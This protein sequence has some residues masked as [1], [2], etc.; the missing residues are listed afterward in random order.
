MTWLSAG[1]I[2]QLMRWSERHVYNLASRHR[3]RRIRHGRR[4]LYHWRDVSDTVNGGTLD[5]T[6]TKVNNRQ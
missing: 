1:D 6:P 2:A 3:W 4:V 5:E